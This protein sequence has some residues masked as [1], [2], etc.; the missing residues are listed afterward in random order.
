[1][2]HSSVLRRKVRWSEEDDR[3]RGLLL[4]ERQ[5]VRA[6]LAKMMFAR[7]EGTKR[8]SY[9]DMWGRCAWQREQMQA[10]EWPCV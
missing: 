3:R 2:S 9:S 1:M 7:L 6:F 10:L 5:R 4:Y 8:L